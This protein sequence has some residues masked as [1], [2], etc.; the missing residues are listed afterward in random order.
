LLEINNILY[1]DRQHAYYY[2]VQAQLFICEVEFCDFILW[3][4]LD[5]HIEHILPDFWEE[6]VIQATKFFYIGIL[7]E[8]MGKWYTKPV[9]PTKANHELTDSEREGPWCYCQESIEGSML[10]GCDNNDCK[11]MWFHMKCLKLDVAPKGKWY[12]PTCMKSI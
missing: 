8:I 10:I 9:I 11:I 2:Q 12:C 6:V 1:L 3:T 5:I 7:P 4:E